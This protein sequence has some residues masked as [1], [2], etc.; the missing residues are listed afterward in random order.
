VR[1]P[2]PVDVRLDDLV[3]ILQTRVR[4]VG[5]GDVAAA[6]IHAASEDADNLYALYR[7]YQADPVYTTLIS[8]KKTEGRHKLPAK[9]RGPR[10]RRAS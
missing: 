1:L 2:P 7:K 4:A 3:E 6:L 10:P 5:R 9:T 8:V